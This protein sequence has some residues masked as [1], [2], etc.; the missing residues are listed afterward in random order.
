MVDAFEDMADFFKELMDTI[1]DFGQGGAAG[2]DPVFEHMRDLGG[3]PV[4]TEEFDEDGN[5]TGDTSLRSS[6]RRTLD[7]AAFEPPSGY[8]RMSMGPQ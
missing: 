6:K 8:K 7:P 4:V 5:K 3:F 1:P 2:G